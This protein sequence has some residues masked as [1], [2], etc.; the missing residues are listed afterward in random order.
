MKT[1]SPD[2]MKTFTLAL[3]S[4]LLAF[5]WT[6]RASTYVTA[7]LTITN[8]TTNGQ[9]LT[10]N[11]D[12]R[13]WTTLVVTPAVQVLT[14]NTVAGVASNLRQHVTLYPF[15]DLT[16]SAFTASTMSL[17]SLD[18]AVI[19]MT[20]SVGWASVSYATNS[21]ASAIGVRV[22]MSVETPTQRTN[23]ATQLSSDLAQY[24]SLSSFPSPESFG[25]T[26]DA[27]QDPVTGVWTGTDNTAAITACLIAKQ[28]CYLKPNS[29]YGIRGFI[30]IGKGEILDGQGSKLVHLDDTNMDGGHPSA[31]N[32]L[33]PW[34]SGAFSGD[35]MVRTRT[36]TNSCFPTIRNVNFDCNG[37]W[38][39]RRVATGA[40]SA[41]D[42][43][44]YT[45]ATQAIWLL[46][47]G[48]T[49]ME[50]TFTNVACYSGILTQ[51]WI[52]EV[53]GLTNTG[54]RLAS[55]PE[56]FGPI[57]CAIAPSLSYWNAGYTDYC[58]QPGPTIINNKIYGPV[59]PQYGTNEFMPPAVLPGPFRAELSLIAAVGYARTVYVTGTTNQLVYPYQ[60]YDGVQINGNTF[61]NLNLYRT[62]DTNKQLAPIHC[63]TPA[64]CRN[65]QVNFNTVEDSF[66]DVFYADNTALWDGEI[67]YN[68]NVGN[69]FQ[70]FNILAAAYTS[71]KNRSGTGAWYRD[72]NVHDNSIGI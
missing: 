7:T 39:H 44:G 54:P 28:F 71:G 11:G 69:C 29:T 24:G 20:P 21:F 19:T 70:G 67:A 9:T 4:I 45:P 66:G 37:G 38:Y 51:T 13:T 65:W 56:S 30:T 15:T 57:Y 3:F 55:V 2:I 40:G 53:T 52:D 8:G 22:P 50:N 25:A 17:R 26:A 5:G 14:N 64:F 48:Q 58:Y 1:Q 60:M 41:T 31:T 47:N 42:D 46:G 35:V 27:V 18:G 6:T 43:G 34:T 16:L 36:D 12:T 33:N 59:V 32:G 61:K 63:I 23:I 68:R 62:S 72:L 49:V 10:V